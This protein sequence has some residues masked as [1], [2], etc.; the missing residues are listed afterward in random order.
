[1]HILTA[2]TNSRYYG[3]YQPFFFS[4]KITFQKIANR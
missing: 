3:G 2:E 1:M 4:T